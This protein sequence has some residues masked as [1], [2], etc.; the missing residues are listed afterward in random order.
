MT[1]I[2]LVAQ[3]TRASSKTTAKSTSTKTAKAKASEKEVKVAANASAKA[4]EKKTLATKAKAVKPAAKAATKP[5]PKAGAKEVAAKVRAPAKP[6]SAAKAPSKTTTR[7]AAPKAKPASVGEPTMNDEVN[8]KMEAGI[9]EME[10]AV[11][12]TQ[13]P[14]AGTRRRSAVVPPAEVTPEMS[15]HDYLLACTPPL[16]TKIIDIAL[17]QTQVPPNLRDDAAQEI[18]MIWHDTKPD[19]KKYQPGQIA[20]YAH[21]MARHAALHARRELGSAVRLPGSAF[22]K[23]KDGSSYVT[24]G[25]LA[26]PLDWNE[27]ESWMQA[28]DMT[29]AHTVGISAM[30]SFDDLIENPES[31]A[32]AVEAIEQAREDNRMA[33]LERC[34]DK[35]TPRQY[36]IMALLIAGKSFED[37]LTAVDIKKGI[38]MR[39][40]AIASS[41][42]AELEDEAE[43]ATGENADE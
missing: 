10:E 2:A 5:A 28:D 23:R 24:P 36:D 22:R 41:L 21:R 40:V 20:S 38:L 17:A 6:K 4:A 29:D 30:P 7:P 43:L 39:E 19:I 14:A 11:V 13:R 25:V 12:E 3:M 26:T 31:S 32:E 8:T 27:L 1:Q 33:Q 9:E 42:L 35:M 18:R 16:A 15:L 34:K 37:I